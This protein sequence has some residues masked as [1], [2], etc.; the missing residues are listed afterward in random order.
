VEKIQ[1]FNA[2]SIDSVLARRCEKEFKTALEVPQ[3][4]KLYQNT[5]EVHVDSV[6]VENVFRSSD[7]Q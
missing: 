3:S 1:Q 4:I 6:H 5:R 7:T 2:G